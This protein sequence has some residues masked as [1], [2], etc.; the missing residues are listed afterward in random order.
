VAEAAF[1]GAL[2][3]PY[4]ALIFPNPVDVDVE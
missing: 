1:A 3:V 2:P 4:R